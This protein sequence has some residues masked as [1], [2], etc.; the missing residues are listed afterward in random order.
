[1]RYSL[2]FTRCK[3]VLWV[4]NRKCFVVNTLKS[5]QNYSYFVG[6]DFQGISTETISCQIPDDAFA[7]LIITEKTPLMPLALLPASLLGQLMLMLFFPQTDIAIEH[8]GSLENTQVIHLGLTFDKNLGLHPVVVLHINL[9]SLS[10]KVT[11]V[12]TIFILSTLPRSLQNEAARRTHLWLN[13]QYIEMLQHFTSNWFKL[14]RCYLQ[15]DLEW[16]MPY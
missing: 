11:A 10:S 4:G 5:T 1:M 6:C 14:S 8:V 9:I 3:S 15:N 13:L 2:V 16:M 7:M 12:W